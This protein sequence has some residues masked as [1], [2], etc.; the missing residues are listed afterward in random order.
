ML[1]VLL[2]LSLSLF[3]QRARS[4]SLFALQRDLAPPARRADVAAG[5]FF[6][7]A[8]AKELRLSRVGECLRRCTTGRCG[9]SK[10]R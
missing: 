3:G 10:A 1:P 2:A 7:R 9:T 5:T 4:Q 8:Y 6:G